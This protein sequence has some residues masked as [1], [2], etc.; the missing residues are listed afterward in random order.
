MTQDFLMETLFF[1]IAE[2]TRENFHLFCSFS[3]TPQYI[4]TEGAS[5]TLDEVVVVIIT[6]LMVLGR[7]YCAGCVCS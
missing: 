3:Y 4:P 7:R 1:Y 6:I 5:D 2:C